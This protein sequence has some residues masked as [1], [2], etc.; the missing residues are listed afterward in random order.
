[1]IITAIKVPVGELTACGY[2][3]WSRESMGRAFLSTMVGLK[4]AGQTGTCQVVIVAGGTGFWPRRYEETVSLAVL[5]D[6]EAGMVLIK[7]ALEAKP[8]NS[9]ISTSEYQ[10]QLL[11]VLVNEALNTAGKEIKP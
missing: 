7:R 4:N 10:Q 1:M 3:R 11:E 9:N 2:R 5:S 6:S 8:G